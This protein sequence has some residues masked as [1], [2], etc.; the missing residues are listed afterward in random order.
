MSLRL[1]FAGLVTALLSGCTV[2]VP[3][4]QA[5]S[6]AIN[7][8]TA[9]DYQE[10]SWTLIYQTREVPVHAIAVDGGIVFSDGND[11]ALAF[12]GWV[13][14][15]ALG[16]APTGTLKIDIDVQVYTIT[17]RFRVMQL[18]CGEWVRMTLSNNTGWFWDLFCVNQSTGVSY[19]NR[20]EIN[21]DNEIVSIQQVI[22]PDGRFVRLVK[23]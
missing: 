8:N 2:S 10:H 19:N 15:R 14:K 9:S 22:D 12:D 23:R 1:L 6:A 7:R 16:L 11:I 17:D 13:I 5:V 4:W 21:E 18:T 20:I 3:Q